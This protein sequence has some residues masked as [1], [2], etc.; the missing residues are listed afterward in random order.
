MGA[1]PQDRSL[2]LANQGGSGC[3]QV[4]CGCRHLEADCFWFRGQH[5]YCK[6][7][8]EELRVEPWEVC[9]SVLESWGTK[10]YLCEL[11]FLNSFCALGK[12]HIMSVLCAMI[13]VPDALVRW[14]RFSHRVKQ[15]CSAVPLQ[16]LAVTLS[17]LR[18]MWSYSWRLTSVSK[19]MFFNGVAISFEILLTEILQ[20]ASGLATSNWVQTSTVWLE[21]RVNIGVEKK[22]PPAS[23]NSFCKSH[24]S[25][26]T[27]N[28][29][30][31]LPVSSFFLFLFGQLLAQ[32][33]FWRS[34]RSCLTLFKKILFA[35]F[36]V[37]V[38]SS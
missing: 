29:E 6:V 5:M 1:W 34:S 2:L 18:G 33:S 32:T 7:K 16:R 38:A 25:S 4:H 14:R 26:G 8:C 15:H 13:G 37:F 27:H 22:T 3:H 28:W 35:W 17:H 30:N 24:F 31:L 20:F 10:V 23:Q 36:F 21:M 12:L 19:I 11:Q 9:N